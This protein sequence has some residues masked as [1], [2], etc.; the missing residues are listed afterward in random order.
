MT[1]DRMKMLI[2]AVLALLALGGC[3]VITNQVVTVNINNDT[4]ATISVGETARLTATHTH[5][6][7]VSCSLG[8]PCQDDTHR[9]ITTHSET[10]WTV[11]NPEIARLGEK[12]NV[13]N[14]YEL[15]GLAPGRT[16]VCARYQWMSHC[17]RLTVVASD[18]L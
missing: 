1:K 15:F 3:S 4:S 18:A 12:N 2:V 16:Q 10:E 5:Y 6:G 14:R 13:S 11:R 9:N 7:K 17:A 8:W